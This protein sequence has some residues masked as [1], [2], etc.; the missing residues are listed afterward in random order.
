M[1]DPAG[2]ILDVVVLLVLI[3]INAFFAMSEIAIITLN[4]NKMRKMAEEGH[5]GAAKVLKLTEDSSRF[6]STIQ[7]GVTLAGFLASAAASE[8][9]AGPLSRLLADWLNITSQAGLNT[10]SVISMVLVTLITSYFSLVLGELAPKRIAMQRSE[11]I[12]FKVV[13]VL[14]FIKSCFAPF[15]RL[16]STSTNAVVRILGY[17]PNASEETVTEEE[18]RLLVDA[19]EE[20]GAIEESEKEMINNIFEFDDIPACD[21]MTHR[22]DMEA[23][24]INDPV[25]DIIDTAISHGYSRIPV[26][27][28]DLD[29]I[30][31][32][33][34]IKDLLKFIGKPIPKTLK[35]STLMRE[36]YFVPESKRCSDLFEEMTEKRLQMVIVADEY[37]GVAGLVTMED[38]LESIVG[39]MQDEYDNED[40][41]VEQV[42]ETTFTIDGVT[43]IEEVNDL[44]D[45]QLPD[46]EYDT[47]GGFIMSEIGR[48]PSPDETVTVEAKGF[49]FTVTEMDERRIE[50]IRAERMEPPEEQKE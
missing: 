48:I 19:G 29:N 21:V 18:I 27:E 28:E 5:K 24:E 22:T 23:V 4:D 43:D 47:I 1:D 15:V 7:I 38:L 32:I 36:A 9:F 20:T 3:L 35:I 12:S 8:N 45:I 40:Q 26:Y 44:L 33:I 2:I 6:L 39:S 50:R 34:Y 49:R 13:G 16:L 10:L 41:E 14:L 11:S 37:G 17:D 31:G 25:D 30:K 42:N 46:G